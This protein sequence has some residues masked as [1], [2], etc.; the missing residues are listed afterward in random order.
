MFVKNL[1]KPIILAQHEVLLPRLKEN[2]PK[3][4]EV[5]DNLRS[6]SAGYYGEMKINYFLNLLPPKKYLIFQDIRLP[7]NDSHFQIDSYLFSPKTSLFIEGKN[8]S[9]TLF[10]E[11]HQLTQTIDSAE[12]I[13]ENPLTQVNRQ[14]LL[15]QNWFEPHQIP[16]IPM[17]HLVCVSNKSSVIKIAQGYIEAE[18]RVCKAEN[19]LMKISEFGDVYKKDVLDPKTI[20][21]M[22]R[23]IIQH[24]VPNKIDVLDRYSINSNDITP[25][26]QCPDCSFIPM[27]YHFGKWICQSC[28]LI[29]KTA[30][31]A[32]IE[33]FYLL[34][35]PYF[36]NAE[37]KEFLRLPSSRIA[38]YQLAP[39]N[40]IPS[41]K[42]KGRVYHQPLT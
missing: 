29:S 2:H 27:Q 28:G 39:L 7:V 26:V 1:T 5:E 22:K 19:L 41:G 11:K 6:L 23:L 33:V 34:I 25:G 15:L 35:K 38:T 9:G 17:E 20:S 4:T 3:R 13:Y 24:H 40:L 14:K 12:K 42:N 37:I 10:F 21:K 18:K 36:T 31:I 30:H 16:K 32:A 8:Y